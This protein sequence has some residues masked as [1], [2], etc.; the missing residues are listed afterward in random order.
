M[1]M[2]YSRKAYSSSFDTLIDADRKKEPKNLNR[3]VPQSTLK[4]LIDFG[5][6]EKS[7]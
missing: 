7:R 1:K 4:L 3:N 5:I 2:I 6:V